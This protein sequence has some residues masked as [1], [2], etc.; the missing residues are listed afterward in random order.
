MQDLMPGRSQGRF[1]ELSE[2][3]APG[4]LLL[5]TD[6]HAGAGGGGQMPELT[7]QTE[8]KILQV[9][10]PQCATVVHHEGQRT[11][12]Q[13]TSVASLFGF[14]ED[15]AGCGSGFDSGPGVKTPW[16]E[17]GTGRLDYGRSEMQPG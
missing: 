1:Q 13:P 4:L 7:E 14:E 3:P 17:S 9:R 10:P 8:D 15:N 2:K 12:Y 5:G 16:E 6:R 11:P